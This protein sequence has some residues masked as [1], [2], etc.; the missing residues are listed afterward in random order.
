ME[1]T[2]LIYQAWCNT[3]KVIQ[4]TKD[5]KG[6][7]ITRELQFLDPLTDK[8]MKETN[9]KCFMCG[10]DM[11]CGV[12][13]KK[14]IKNTFTDWNRMKNITGTHIC[15]ACY[16]CIA[17]NTNKVA[18]RSFSHV[19][20]DKLYI[21]NRIE[22]RG[23][24]LEPP[25]PPFVIDL[26]VSQK[27]HICFK[28]DVQYSRDIFHVQYEEMPVLVERRSFSELLTLVEHFLYG[29][30]KT[31]ISTGEYQTPRIL[32]FGIEA[33]EAFEEKVKPYR[34]MPILD[35]VMFVAQKVEEEEKLKCYMDSELK[36]TPL[37]APPLSSTP[38]TVAATKKKGRPASICGDKLND[39]QEQVQN[40]QLVLDLF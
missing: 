11:E 32:K 20:A 25:E 2:H 3:P 33:W 12:P 30:T 38:S 10:H 21:P 37:P 18:L 35:V 6:N 22:L 1:T 4:K 39:L 26:A 19:A 36:I 14:A 40:E 34:G 7:E 29:F 13:V 5:S 15:S 8:N 16:F 23:F 27:K 24:I 9:G 28:G 31:E 17:T